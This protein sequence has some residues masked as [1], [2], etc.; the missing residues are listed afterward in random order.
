VVVAPKS[1]SLDAN[2]SVAVYGR[3]VL[4]SGDV[5]N[6]RAGDSVTITEHRVPAVGGVETKAVA[7][8]K[9]A[10]DGSFSLAVRPLIRTLYRRQSARRRATSS[11]C[12]CGR[13]CD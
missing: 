10:A 3:T 13:C 11:P 8:V 6:A 1:I 2:R 9:T 4:L 7:T 12:A 5:R